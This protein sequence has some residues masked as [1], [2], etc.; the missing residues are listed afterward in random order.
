MLVAQNG[1]RGRQQIIP[2][3][4]IADLYKVGD[5]DAWNNGSFKDFFESKAMH[6]RSKWYVCQDAGQLLHGFGIHGQYLF[7]DQDKKLSIAW[8]SSEEDPLDSEVSRRILSMVNEIRIA[9]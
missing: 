4:W 6:Y 8:L 1:M 9:L 2:A 5:R 3:E 7:V